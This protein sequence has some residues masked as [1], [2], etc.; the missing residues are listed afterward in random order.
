MGAPEGQVPAHRP[1]PQWL[2]RWLTPALLVAAVWAWVALRLAGAGALPAT[3]GVATAVSL[4]LYG[5]EQLMPDR[6]VPPRTAGTLLSDLLFNGVTSVSAVLLPSLLWVPLGHRAGVALGSAAL[7]PAVLPTWVSVL[8]CLLLVDFTTYWWHRIEHTSGAGWPWR[9]HSVHHSPTHFDVW[10]G[11]RVHPLDVT[12]FSWVGYTFVALLG[13][14]HFVVEATAFI[15][16]M[17]GAMHHTRVA[18]DCGFIN[19][20]IP[21]AD[22]HLVHHSAREADNGNFG[23]ITTLFDQLFGSYIAPVPRVPPPV[24]AFSLA[25]DYPQGAFLFQ[26]LSPFGER[27]RRAKRAT[28]PAP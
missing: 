12:V 18:T 14:P 17:V 24:G 22:H 10:M 5:F 9:L 3:L 16:S 25:D 20:L 21:M 28:R 11:A 19:R 23:N 15:A 6:A 4:L 27:W 13:A 7:W 26:L 8:L 1:P 2:L